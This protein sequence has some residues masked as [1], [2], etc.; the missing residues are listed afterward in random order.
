MAFSWKESK[1]RCFRKLKRRIVIYEKCGRNVEAKSV[2]RRI[3]RMK[4]FGQ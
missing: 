3:D 2:A 4:R 1:E